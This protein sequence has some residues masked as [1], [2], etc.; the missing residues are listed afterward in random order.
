MSYYTSVDKQ[1]LYRLPFAVAS[2][3]LYRGDVFP[4]DVQ[5]AV[6]S[7]RTKQTIHFVDWCP[8]GFKVKHSSFIMHHDILTSLSTL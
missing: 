8:T 5:A 3:L 1:V 7:V 2:C 4:K 6:A